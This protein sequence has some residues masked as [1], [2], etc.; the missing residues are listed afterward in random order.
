VV[1][2]G[3]DLLLELADARAVCPERR[4]EGERSAKSQ[5]NGDKDYSDPAL[6]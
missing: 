2:S 1:L 4:E 5:T 3:T 6:I